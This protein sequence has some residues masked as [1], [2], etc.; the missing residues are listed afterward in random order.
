MNPEFLTEGQAVS[1]FLKPDRIVL[2]GL[3]DRAI[4][5]MAKLYAGVSLA[6]LW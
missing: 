6:Y 2:G 1:D 3:D 4:A 5:T